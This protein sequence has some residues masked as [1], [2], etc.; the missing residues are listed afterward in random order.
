MNNIVPMSPYGYLLNIAL[1]FNHRNISSTTPDPY[2]SVSIRY[3]LYGV[4]K[5]EEL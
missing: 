3:V 2:V 1:V 4:R 5:Y